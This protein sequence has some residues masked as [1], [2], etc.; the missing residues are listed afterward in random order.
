[1]GKLNIAHHK[2]YHPYRRDNIERVRRDEEEAR[3][4]EAVAEGRML[5]ADS[6]ARIDLLRQRAGAQ[7]RQT[8]DHIDAAPPQAGPSSITSGGHINFFE[9]LERQAL[10]L[11]VRTTKKE[12]VET[13][14]GIPLAPSAKDLKPWYSDHNSEPAK[15]LDGDRRLRD[16]ARKSVNDPLTSINH[17]LAS[18]PSNGLASSRA[19]AAVPSPHADRGRPEI[20]RLSRE[21]SERQRAVELIRRKKREMEGSE[22]PST[23]RG[24][25]DGGYGDVFNRREVEEAHRH[26]ERRWDGDGTGRHAGPVRTRW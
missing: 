23:V 9:D 19:R 1:M 20:A 7:R 22:T 16:L 11:S 8:D 12:P 14:K 21:S 24:G 15:E 10:P 25:M 26:R 17:Q 18:R 5:L 13:D 4:Q 3:T 6:E 2:S